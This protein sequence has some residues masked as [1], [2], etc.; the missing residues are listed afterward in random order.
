M[1]L[2]LRIVRTNDLTKRSYICFYLKGKRIREYNGNSLGL[3]IKPNKASTVQERDRL[4]KKLEFELLKALESNNYPSVE[5]KTTT[6]GQSNKTL[7]TQTLLQVALD[8]KLN[9]NYSKYYKKNMKLLHRHFTEFLSPIE[10]TSP[11][12][13]IKT[14]RVEQ[15]LDRYKTSGTYYMDKRRELGVLFSAIS[16]KLEM[17]IL[18][19]QKTDRMKTKAKLHKIY[20]QKQILKVLDYLKSN[21]ENL[22]L[23]CLLS[24]GTFL[25]PHREIR[26]LCAHHFKKNCSE[27]HLSGD[28]NKSGRIR[29]VPIPDYVRDILLPKLSLL[30]QDHNIFSN[31]VKPL[32]DAYFGTAWTRIW[33][34]MH[35]IGIIEKHQTIYSFR[36]TAAVHVYRKT[37]DIHIIQQ[38]LGHSDMIVTL[39]YLRGLGELNLTE[40]KQYMPTL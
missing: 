16:K 36:H 29:V 18:T 38:L 11:I 12:T 27:I 3:N 20:D 17:K 24:Y 26:N 37:K 5:V 1:S 8:S 35:D 22:H 31:S 9:S 25:R 6:T 21:H 14:S 30:E 32:N 19:V 28:E 40:Q 4:L 33:R 23:C 10:L 2:E 7:D 39:K 34:K 15:F 13:E